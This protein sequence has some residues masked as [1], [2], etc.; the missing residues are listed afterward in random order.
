M[1]FHHTLFQYPLLLLAL[2]QHAPQVDAQAGP[3]VALEQVNTYAS[4]LGSASHN[5]AADVIA[6]SGVN[7]QVAAA[8]QVAVDFERSNWATGSVLDDPFYI[9]PSNASGALP[10]SILKVQ[11]DANATDFTLPPQVAIS[12]FIFQTEDLNGTCVPNSAFV[13]WPW[14]P[15]RFDNVSGVPVIVWGHGTSGIS[16]EAGPSHMQ[17]LWYQYASPFTLAL[18]GYAVIAPDFAGL[19]IN[20]TAGGEFIPHQW[21]ANP[22]GANDMFYAVQA[23][24]QAWPTELSEEFVIMVSPAIPQ[25]PATAGLV[26]LL[27]NIP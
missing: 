10:G 2:F 24:Q 17:D 21:G 14:M 3:P 9:I 26:L 25:L 11:Q 8:V 16:V 13:L 5:Q 1:V 18:Q 22:A 27:S 4:P 6:A 23:A 15:R 7:P 20:K 19:G 12:R